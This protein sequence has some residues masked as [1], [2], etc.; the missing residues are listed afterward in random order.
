MEIVDFLCFLFT[1]IAK[2]GIKNNKKS[3]FLKMNRTKNEEKKINFVC[4]REFVRWREG[5]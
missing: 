1:S 4:L 5:N 3:A 2:Y